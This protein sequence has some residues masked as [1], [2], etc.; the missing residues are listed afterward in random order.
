MTS[1][2]VL[3]ATLSAPELSRLAIEL[4]RRGSLTQYVRPYTNKGRIWERMLEHTPKLGSLYRRTL[5][6]RVPPAGLSPAKV[7]EAGT[8]QDFAAAGIG[9]LPLGSAEHRHRLVQRM[10]FATEIAV[11][12][13]AGRYARS[14]DVV[15]ASYGTGVEGFAA[16]KRVGGRAVL[17]YPAAHNR[18]QRKLM[19]EDARLSPEFAAALPDFDAVPAEF[20]RRRDRECA[21]ADRILVAS[22]FAKQAFVAEGYDPE[23]IVAIAFGVDTARFSPPVT[24]RRRNRFRVLFVGHVGQRKGVSYLLQGYESF[25]RPDSELHLVGSFVPGAA[26]VYDRFSALFL[27]TPHVPQ[28]QL[29]DIYRAADVFVLP[30]LT[31]GMPLVVLEAMASGLPVIATPNGPSD[32]IENG[33][34]G[35][36]VPIRNPQAIAEK[37]Q[38]LYQDPELR[39]TLGRR[40]REKALRFGWDVYARRAA[41][42]VTNFQ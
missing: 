6:R 3:V 4:D 33:T 25:R 10:S 40:A 13:T 20:E 12:R 29:P 26:Q 41:D 24:P 35:F 22:S 39:A 31:E 21:E 8:L 18:Y 23:K 37:L 17:H 14:A 7:I 42:A 27:H 15:V 16:V 28:A 9:R 11:A 34:D 5:G 30:T 19:D 32:L 1:P 38:V 36:I 2:R